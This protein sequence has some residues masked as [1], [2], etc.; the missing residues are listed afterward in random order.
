M[1]RYEFAH[2]STNI[3]LIHTFYISSS[4]QV[5]DKV[6]VAWGGKNYNCKVVSMEVKIWYLLSLS[7]SDY[8]YLQGGGSGGNK[9]KSSLSWLQQWLR[10]VACAS[11]LIQSC[12]GKDWDW[13]RKCNHSRYTKETLPG[14]R[15]WSLRGVIAPS[16]LQTSSDMPP[17]YKGMMLRDQE[18]N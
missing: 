16:D 10:R 18:K 17:L 15:I 12:R 7:F 1:W 14:W 5:G 11:K 9:G 8:I 4:T 13:C 2:P 3:L 6:T